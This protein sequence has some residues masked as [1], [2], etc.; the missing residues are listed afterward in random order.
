MI[1]Q[2]PR[3]LESLRGSK[4]LHGYCMFGCY[5]VTSWNDYFDETWLTTPWIACVP[6]CPVAGPLYTIVR[7]EY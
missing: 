2:K 6:K 5:V 1:M 7:F 4:V 3:E